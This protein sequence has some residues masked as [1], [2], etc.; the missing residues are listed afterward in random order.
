MYMFTSLMLL[1]L[2]G[3]SCVGVALFIVLAKYL[4]TVLCIYMVGKDTQ[5]TKYC[6][7]YISNISNF[8]KIQRWCVVIDEMIS[9]DL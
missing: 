8:L 7:A 2:V 1:V 3:A 4:I 5:D 9:C 6:I